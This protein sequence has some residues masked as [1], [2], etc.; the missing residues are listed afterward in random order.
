MAQHYMEFVKNAGQLMKTWEDFLISFKHIIVEL[1]FY[2]NTL[3]EAQIVEILRL[4]DNFKLSGLPVIEYRDRKYGDHWY[5]KS[6]CIEVYQSQEIKDN[7]L[8]WDSRTRKTFNPYVKL[9][10]QQ[11]ELYKEIITAK[12]QVM[13]CPYWIINNGQEKIYVREIVGSFEDLNFDY[14]FI[15]GKEGRTVFQSESIIIEDCYY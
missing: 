15:I 11:L 9:N 7:R 6:G 13:V 4:D 10:T 14:P 2:K 8:Y 12:Y 3:S 5:D 1:A